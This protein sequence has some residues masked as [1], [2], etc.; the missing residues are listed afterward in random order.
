MAGRK[1]FTYPV[2]GSGDQPVSMSASGSIETDNYDEGDG[3]DFD[4]SAYPYVLNPAGRMIQEW[5][6]TDC[7][8]VDAEIVT[9]SGT[10]FT[11]RLNGITGSFDKWSIDKI[12]FRDP[13]AT[14]APLSGAWAGD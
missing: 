5:I 9:K 6:I 8:D 7:G 1:E 14:A 3:F 12:T 4:G 13:R 11:F 2:G 10:T